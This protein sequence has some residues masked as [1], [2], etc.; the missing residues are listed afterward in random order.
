MNALSAH[1]MPASSTAP[2]ATD[3]PPA[4]R[5]RVG[6]F[7][8]AAG[9]LDR[10]NQLL[11][12]L[13]HCDVGLDELATLSRRL[14]PADGSDRPSPWIVQRLRRGV[15]INL[16]VSDPSWELDEQRA[17]AAVVV[18]T[19][20][21]DRNDLI[22]DDLPRIGRFDDAF[23]ID[24]AWPQLAVEVRSYLDF[25][26]V[27][28]VEAGLRGCGDSDFAFSRSAWREASQAEKAWIAHCRETGRRSYLPA[29][30]ADHFRVC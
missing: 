11:A 24:A 22:P 27:R 1:C 26:R 21:R 30:G 7:T 29:R 5:R 15:T 3:T 13:G 6:G 23:V 19:Y 18:A 10:F 14:A 25:C 17:E 20:L 28:H 9:A 16:M 2:S 8:V 4:R 12:R